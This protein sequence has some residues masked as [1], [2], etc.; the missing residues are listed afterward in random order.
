MIK[1]LE[2]GCF[3]N[4]RNFNSEGGQYKYVKIN[5]SFIKWAKDPEKI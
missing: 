1:M 2:Y 5:N 4:K 3:L